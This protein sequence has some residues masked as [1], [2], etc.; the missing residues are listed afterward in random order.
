MAQ[1]AELR[2]SCRTEHPPDWWFG[3]GRTGSSHP[4]DVLERED[5]RENRPTTAIPSRFQASNQNPLGE[6]AK[7]REYSPQENR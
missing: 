1:P 5:V 7:I 6:I 4:L 2:I 3:T